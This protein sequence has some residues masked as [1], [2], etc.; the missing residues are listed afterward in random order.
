MV[1]AVWWPGYLAY[2]LDQACSYINTVCW[3]MLEIEN[4]N[5]ER[6]PHGGV[7]VQAEMRTKDH[8]GAIVPRT[9]IFKTC[10]HL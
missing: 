2:W 3:L 8:N 1:Q 10:M 5:G 4:F 7:K 6:Y 9:E